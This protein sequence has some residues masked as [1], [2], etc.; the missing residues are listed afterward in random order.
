MKSV[1]L[2]LGLLAIHRR[3]LQVAVCGAVLAVAGYF[4][5]ANAVTFDLSQHGLSG[6][7]GSADTTLSYGALWRTQSR[8]PAL[9]SIASGGTDRDPNT[10]NGDLNYDQGDMV[11]SIFRIGEELQLKYKNYTVFA[12]GDYFYDVRAHQDRDKFN[13]QGQDLL[14][15]KARLL[16]AFISGD[17]NISG[18]LL[19]V[20]VGRQVINWGE[21]T[22]IQNGLNAINVIDVN[23]LRQ[24]GSEL[25]DALLPNPAFT[26]SLGITDNVSIAGF[27]LTSFH[28]VMLDPNG[29]FFSQTDSLSEGGSR[30]YLGLGREPGGGPHNATPSASFI[31]RAPNDEP[32][33]WN[34]FGLAL[35]YVVPALNYAEFGLYYEHLAS[36]VPILSVIAQQNQAVPGTGMING[37]TGVPQPG[38][39]GTAQYF[40]DYPS[41]I[42]VYGLS[43][44]TSLP[45]GI[46]LQGEYT[47]RP[48]LPVQIAPGEVALAALELPSLIAPQIGAFPGGSV[49]RGYDR[50]AAH[51][52]QFTL[53]RLFAD[54]GLGANQLVVLSEFGANYL[55][56]PDNMKFASKTTM[57]ILAAFYG[58]NGPLASL[59][60]GSVQTTG[61]LT[62][63]SWG[64]RAVAQLKYLN[65]FHSVNVTPN[66]AF[67][68]DVT[69][70][71]P[72]FNQ[73]AKAVTLG[74]DFD[75]LNNWHASVAYTN[76]FGGHIHN[77]GVDPIP[78][79]GQSSFY[80]TEANGMK[81]RDFVAASVSYSF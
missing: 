16:D 49:I 24:P 31:S 14:I 9:I 18:H 21:S 7:T 30:V 34:Q 47:Y 12:R 42:N 68:Q 73:G 41:G 80:K 4:P 32:H 6:V 51:Q 23:N 33:G 40:E 5:Y 65:L 8:D 38:A 45:F 37:A 71:G 1:F 28:H 44:A 43:F 26:F 72:N 62:K 78:T 46:A 52:F 3:R 66:L 57:P 13:Q 79:P 25:K 27:V 48:N 60:N 22:F 75:Y 58:A 55:D 76:F 53:T 20:R 74:V 50:L 11:N 17:Y 61:F 29:A 36:H 10:G 77:T 54:P 35:H 19:N 2:I 59:T 67:S 39:D 56:L 15:D 70:I 63:F 69:G 64:Y 81:D